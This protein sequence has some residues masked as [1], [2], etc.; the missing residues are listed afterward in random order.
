MSSGTDRPDVSVLIV[1]VDEPYYIPKFLR[2]VVEADYVDVVG[3]TTTPP[4]LG[5]EGTLSFARRM[6]RSFGP[7][8][9]TKL[10]LFYGTFRLLELVARTLNV[11]GTYSPRQ[12]A[13]RNGIEYRKVTDV[14]APEYVSY[15]RALS[16]DILLSVAATQKFGPELLSVPTERA[17]NVHS[18]LLPE[19]RGVSP[20][21]WAL[22]HDEDT[23]GV[24]VHEM[25]EEID[26]GD[27]VRQRSLPILEDDTLH[28]LNTRVAER[29]SQVLIDA[30]E[31]IRTGT[32]VPEPIDSSR[33]E[34]YSMPTRADVREFRRRG[35][36][37][38]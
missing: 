12:L 14:N 4:T 28:S 3:I 33:G 23:T 34:Y 15:A 6:L 10:G 17:I 29:G 38:Y 26:T 30:I 20:S 11:G 1:T 36:R 2:P 19:Y 9:F 16:P 35:N 25:A 22:M 21:F 13:E 27:I 7:V 18:S 5:S 32:D 24:T 37:F 31:D 8:V